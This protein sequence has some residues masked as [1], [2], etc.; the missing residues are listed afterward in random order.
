MNNVDIESTV[1]LCNT[2]D[3]TD[4]GTLLAAHV[5]LALTAAK[6]G[7]INKTFNKTCYCGELEE[8]LFHR[9]RECA[10]FNAARDNMCPEIKDPDVVPGPLATFGLVQLQQKE[11]DFRKMLRELPEKPFQQLEHDD[12]IFQSDGFVEFFS[13]GSM[14]END[15]DRWS[16]V[17]GGI[18]WLSRSHGAQSWFGMLPGIL[19]TITRGELMPLLG[20][21]K[22]LEATDFDI[23]VFVDNASMVQEACEH[24]TLQGNGRWRPNAA[25]P[26]GDWWT[27]FD[28]AVARSIGIRNI[29]VI[30]VKGH[31]RAED[32]QSEHDAYLQWGNDQAD[33]AAKK[34]RML[35]QL[36]RNRIM[37]CIRADVTKAQ[38]VQKFILHVQK[39]HIGKA[40]RAEGVF[41]EDGPSQTSQTEGCRHSGYDILH[42]KTWGKEW[43]TA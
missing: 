11:L 21:V 1:A 42:P 15:D 20:L 16:L 2:W 36:H 38:R 24:I 12:M 25:T 13:D 35:L 6:I 37:H 33:T 43:K 34:G 7:H 18:I 39:E 5:G 27:R 10:I 29:Q 32:V 14:D 19:R 41:G 22:I 9:Y 8:D 4:K 26:N 23:K 30:K 17:G 40:S 28:K 31:V 3:P